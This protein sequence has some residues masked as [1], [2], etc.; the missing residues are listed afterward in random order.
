MGSHESCCWQAVL[1]PLQNFSHGNGIW[2]MV[3][4]NFAV[5]TACLY[6]YYILQ[7][8]KM[9]AVLGLYADGIHYKNFK[10]LYAISY[11]DPFHY[12]FGKNCRTKLERK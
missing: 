8:Q 6:T 1:K 7:M 4:V 3:T 11:M 12:P 10:M 5:V 9:L 2:L